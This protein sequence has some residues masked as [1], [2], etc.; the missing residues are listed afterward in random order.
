[1]VVRMLHY[2]FKVAD[3]KKSR[4]FFVNVLKMKVLRHEEFDEGCKATCNGPYD[5]K[6]SK[7]MVGYGSEDDH[8]VLE[9][10]YNYP[11]KSYKLGNDFEG[12]Y[13]CSA[14]VFESCRTSQMKIAVT[15][16]E[17][18][19]RDPDGHTFYVSS[20]DS[21]LHRKDPIYKVKLNTADMSKTIDYWIGLLG[22]V[23][24]KRSDEV[25]IVSDDGKKEHQ[26]EWNLVNEKIERCTGFGR[27]AFSVPTEELKTIQNKIEE[28][29]GKILTP[30]QKLD[31]AGKA[32][33]Q[34]VI[35]ADPNDHE[36]CFVGEEAF[37]ELSKVDPDADKSLLEAIEGDRSCGFKKSAE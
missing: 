4:D 27:I 11:I 2:V 5:N 17:I 14:E 18:K 22:M 15:D 31:T 6:W 25:L 33:V 37:H 13:I 32:S 36:I 26:L 21:E 34:V 8:F 16:G 29:K 20:N 3:R 12:I 1:M 10:T 24:V 7:T 35:L 23:E 19:I 28:A 30:L 9:L